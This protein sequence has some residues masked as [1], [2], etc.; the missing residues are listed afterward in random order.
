MGNGIRPS[1]DEVSTMQLQPAQARLCACQLS[2]SEV[3][4]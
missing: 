3:I 1:G 4:N 2:T